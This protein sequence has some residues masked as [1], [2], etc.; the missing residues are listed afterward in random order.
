MGREDCTMPCRHEPHV[1]LG[2]R[3]PLNVQHVAVDRPLGGA[4]AGQMLG[5][6]ERH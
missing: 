6:L 5:R 4:E 3:G 1:Q 2:K